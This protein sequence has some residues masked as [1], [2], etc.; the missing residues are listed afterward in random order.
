VKAAARATKSKKLRALPKDRKFTIEDLWQELQ[1]VRAALEES[2]RRC[3]RLERRVKELEEES[4]SLR[5]S[6]WATEEFLQGQIRKLEKD[7]A[8][9]DRKLEKA[10]KQ[11]AWFRKTLFDKKSEKGMVAEEEAATEPESQD[12]GQ[13][14]VS[15]EPPP[16]KRKRGQQ[17]G[18]KGH[19][20]TDRSSVPVA[21]TV[22]LEIPGGCACPDCGKP[23]LGRTYPL[24]GRSAH[25]APQ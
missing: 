12:G 8:D 1:Q 24:S 10:D 7:V 23:Y 2:E 6:R 14:D 5:K 22:T 19:G 13:V 20:R 16:G 4:S 17:P 11:L 18:S 21:E 15:P 9:R 3:E 25:S